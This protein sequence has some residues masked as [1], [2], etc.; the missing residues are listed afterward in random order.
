MLEGRPASSP[1]V[2]PPREGTPW[3]APGDKGAV[4]LEQNPA[5]VAGGNCGEEGPPHRRHQP[6]GGAATPDGRKG[7][8]GKGQAFGEHCLALGSWDAVAFAST[9]WPGVQGGTGLP[10]TVREVPEH[11]NPTVPSRPTLPCL[12]SFSPQPWLV[13]SFDLS[14]VSTLWLQ[15]QDAPSPRRHSPGFC[16]LIFLPRNPSPKPPHSAGVPAVLSVF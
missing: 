4:A 2:H 5:P 11:P 3:Q 9:P 13:W 12:G 10:R 7:A 1:S 14:P 15:V 16:I 6:L 8:L